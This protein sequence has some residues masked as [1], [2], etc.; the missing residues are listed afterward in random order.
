MSGGHSSEKP[1]Q[2]PQPQPPHLFQPQARAAVGGGGGS[3]MGL[4]GCEESSLL[5]GRSELWAVLHPFH[6]DPPSCVLLV[7]VC[8]GGGAQILC[9]ETAE[10]PL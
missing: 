5:V 1:A 3:A 7:S 4:D 10:R 6:E 9:L 2:Q 8:P